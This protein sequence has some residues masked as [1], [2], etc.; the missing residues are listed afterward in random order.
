MKEKD[1]NLFW[2]WIITGMSTVILFFC[3]SLRHFLFQSN[4]L[5]L[6]WFDQAIFLISQGNTP[7]VSFVDNHILG[8]H[9]AFILYPLALFYVIYPN[10]HWLFA[11]QAVALSFGAVPVY[12]LA[13]KAGLQ[14]NLALTMSA[15]Y[16]LYPLVFNLNIFDFHSEVIALPI[17]FWAILAA[18]N[19]NFYRFLSAII[20]ILS[21]K[22][23]LSLTVAAMG[24]WL[25]FF[26]RKRLCGSTA[27]GLGVFW[28]LITTQVIIPQFSGE[29]VAAL[30]R[31]SFLGDS[32]GEILK[33]FFLNPGIFLN[34]IFTLANLEYLIL[35]VCPVIWGLSFSH[36]TPMVAAIPQLGLNLLTD[37][38]PQKDLV[39]QYS[40]PIIPFLLLS[41]IYTLA[42]RKKIIKY[43]KIIICWSLITFLVLAKYSYFG[44]KYLEQLDTLFAM[45]Q[46]VELVPPKVRVLTSPQIAPHLTHRPVVKLG[47]RD[48]ESI[49]INNFDYIMLNV[50]H[51]SWPKSRKTVIDLV[52][53]IR[54][55][56]KFISIH[57]QDN[58]FMFKQNWDIE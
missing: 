22:A 5:D 24:L 30:G 21:C 51:P 12:R 46:G 55:N 27:L 47:I 14:K 11:I 2:L 3:A 9:A 56:R 13:Q 38:Q 18:K 6:G 15:V 39:H 53:K 33:N 45:R 17:L 29:K 41:N 40:L 52:K 44:S 20:I 28:F 36:L 4:A 19:N 25:L 54:K 57:E 58:V 32:V 42:T 7:I 35:L 37:Y 10:V 50:R 31:Y 43:H 49:D 1:S 48:A 26:E 16:L 34:K 8:D 23:V